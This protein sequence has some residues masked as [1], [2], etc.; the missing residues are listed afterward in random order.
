MD[1]LEKL[2]AFEEIRTLRAR[3]FRG[4]DTQDW[5]MMESVFAPDVVFDIR[6][7]TTDPRTG[8]SIVPSVS[9][10]VIVGN[11]AVVQAISA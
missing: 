11:K 8:V 5:V 7:A 3:Y 6:S 9:E 10:G 4:A 2:V 1:N